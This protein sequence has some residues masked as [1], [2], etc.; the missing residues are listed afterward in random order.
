MAQKKPAGLGRG[1]G[2]LLE[3]NTP[4]VKGHSATVVIRAEDG[5]KNMQQTADLYDGQKKPQNKS[6][7]ANFR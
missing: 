3:D 1:L 7:K 5:N 2:D 6:L 4:V